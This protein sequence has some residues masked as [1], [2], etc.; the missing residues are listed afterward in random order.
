MGAILGSSQGLK[1]MAAGAATGVGAD[2]MAH[3]AREYGHAAAARAAESMSKVPYPEIP[4]GAA[5]YFAN[6]LDR[7][8]KEK[9]NK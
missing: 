2:A 5:G 9:E 4:P 6:L 1:G 7:I 3:L 8:N